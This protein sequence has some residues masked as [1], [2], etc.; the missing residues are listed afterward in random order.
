VV[1][2]I[3]LVPVLTPA[4]ASRQEITG[5]LSQGLSGVT[6]PHSLARPLVRLTAASVLFL[7]LGLMSTGAKAGKVAA[8]F[9]GLV[10]AGV[11]FNATNEISTLAA[12]FGSKTQAAATE[13]NTP[14]TTA[15]GV[16]NASPQIIQPGGTGVFGTNPTSTPGLTQPTVPGWRGSVA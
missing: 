6:N 3:A 15:P 2:L 5:D 16:Q 9:G 14:P 4:G 10:V 8:A 11:L 1:I 7:I 12:Y 13:A